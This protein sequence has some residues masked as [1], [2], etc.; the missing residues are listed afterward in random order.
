MNNKE[1]AIMELSQLLADLEKIF[2]GERVYS[3]DLETQQKMY[4]ELHG[5]RGSIVGDNK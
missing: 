3:F 5:Y 2:R 4:F 1:G